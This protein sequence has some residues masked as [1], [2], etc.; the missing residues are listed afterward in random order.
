MKFMVRFLSEDRIRKH[1][2]FPLNYEGNSTF[3]YVCDYR[4]W[5]LI[6]MQYHIS[7]GQAT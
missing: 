4:L 3:T 1:Q 5:S 7:Y 6:P 2:T